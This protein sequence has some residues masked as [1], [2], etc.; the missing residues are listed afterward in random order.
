MGHPAVV[1]GQGA[2]QIPPLRFAPVDDKGEAIDF[3]GGWIFGCWFLHA[4][5]TENGTSRAVIPLKP[6]DGLTRNFLY[7]AAS[8][9]H[10]CSFD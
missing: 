2:P 9:G 4:W 7:A 10:V 3:Y 1:C 5:R 6:K 8:N